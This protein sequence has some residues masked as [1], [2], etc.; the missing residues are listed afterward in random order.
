MSP[1]NI[2]AGFAATGIYPYNRDIF[3]DADFAAAEV[4]D[5]Q[6]PETAADTGTTLG[7]RELHDY[8][9]HVDQVGK[10][11]AKCQETVP[12]TNANGMETQQSYVL[13]CHTSH[14]Q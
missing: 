2:K 10:D 5:R 12:S 1:R 4:T 14:L 7:E 11:S 9:C 3:T 6:N 8:D 13:V